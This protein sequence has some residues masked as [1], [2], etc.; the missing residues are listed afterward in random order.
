MDTSYLTIAQRS[1]SHASFR[2]SRF[3]TLSRSALRMHV[4]YGEEDACV[5][6]QVQDPLP[7]CPE[8]ACASYGEED[9]CP[10][11]LSKKNQVPLLL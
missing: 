3:R 11:L 6:Y 10:L 4:S 8:D 2:W 1:T 7:L 9:A 5:S